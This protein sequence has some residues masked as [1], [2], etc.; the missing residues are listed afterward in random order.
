[1]TI[2]LILLQEK[3]KLLFQ[4]AQIVAIKPNKADSIHKKPRTVAIK[5]NKTDSFHTGGLVLQ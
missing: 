1:M 2:N 3:T 4:M 5:P